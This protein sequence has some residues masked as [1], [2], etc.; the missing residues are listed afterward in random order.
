VGSTCNYVRRKCKHKQGIENPSNAAYNR[1]IYRTIREN[2]EW[3]MQIY[4]E[5]P[6]ENKT[7]MRIRE[8]EV[9]IELRADLNEVRCYVSDEKK[10]EL[11][12]EHYEANKEQIKEQRR[13]RYKNETRDKEIE[14]S[15]N[16]YEN[17]R[18]RKKE[19]Q[20]QRY[21]DQKNRILTTTPEET[22]SES[23]DNEKIN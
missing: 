11:K 13:D 2:G 12:K 10:K 5:Y 4:E 23:S 14:N 16:W 3:D 8:E 7:Q 21:Q 15:K 1:K 17:N 6:C 19:Y 20:R 22:S 9:R 18:E